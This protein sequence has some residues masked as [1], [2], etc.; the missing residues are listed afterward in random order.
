MGDGFTGDGA[1][2]IALIGMSGRYPGAR[3]LRE[4]WHNLCAGVESISFFSEPELRAAGVSP[5][6]L[7]SGHYVPARGVLDDIEWFDAGFFGYAPREAELM[8]PQHRIFLECAWEA[9]E[10]AGYDPGRDPGL[11][12]VYAG[13]GLNTY[14]LN[15]LSPQ[16]ELLEAVGFYQVLIGNDKDYLATRV[17][18]KLN[19]K[20][21]SMTVQTA[22]STSLVAVYQACQG[23]LTYQCDMALAGGVAIWVPHRVGYLHTQGGILSP[24]GHCRAFDAAAQGTVVGNGVGIVVLKRLDDAL[25]DGDHIYA[26]IQ[27]IACNNDG[28]DKIGFTAPGVAGQARVIREALALANVD[29]ATISYVEAH[30]TGTPLGDPIEMAALAQ[31]FRTPGE[32]RGTCAIGSV[33]SNIGHTDAAAGVAGLIKTALA[34]QHRQI[35]PSLHLTAVNPK[36]DLAHS[37]FTVQQ[38]LTP[39]TSNGTPRRAGVSSFGLGGTNVHAVLEEAPPRRPASPGRPWQ[40]LLLSARSQAGVHAAAQRLAEH[41]QQ[42]PDTDLADVAYT[43]AVGRRTFAQRMAVVCQAPGDAM[44]ALA[45]SSPRLYDGTARSVVFMFSGQGAQH[46]DMGCALYAAEPIFRQQVDRCAEQLVPL[47]GLD[48]REVLF[49]S[50]EQTATMAQLL[51]ETWITQPALFTIEYAL[52]QLWLA[53]GIR[54]AALIGHSIGEY[55]AACLAG[56]MDLADA[57]RLVASRGQLMQQ[58]APGAMLAVMQP[59]AEVT[60]LLPDQLS[61]AAINGPALCVVS[62]PLAGIEALEQVLVAR[63]IEC[64]RLQ[65]SHAFHSAMMDP[66]AAS[67][68]T[69]ASQID[70][71]PPQIPFVSNVTGDWITPAAAT[72]PAYWA[73]HLRAPVQFAQGIQTILHDPRRI[74]LEVGPGRT[75]CTLA[76]Q[77]RG[78]AADL[79]VQNSLP[80]PQEPAAEQACL[81]QAL[82]RLWQAGVEVDWAAFYAGQRRRRV[83]LPTYPF[84]RQYYWIEAPQVSSSADGPPPTLPAAPGA[85]F[86]SQGPATALTDGPTA[87]SATAGAAGQATPVEQIVH[88]AWQEVLGVKQVRPDDSFFDLG[89]HSLQAV[90]LAARLSTQLRRE[91]PV[92]LILTNPRVAGLAAALSAAGDHAPPRNGAARPLPA[93][94]M[95]EAR[96]WPTVAT[97]ERR[98]LLAL[99]AAGRLA[100]VDAAALDY[101]PNSLLQNTGLRREEIIQAWCDDLPVV[102]S[103]WEIPLGRMAYIVLPRFSADL[104]SDP[105]DAVRVVIEGLQVA[106]RLGA[107]TVSLTGLIPSATDYGRAVAAA[108]AGRRDLPQITT[109]HATTTASVVLAIR[110]MLHEAGRDLRQERLAFVGLGS[111]GL[112]SL[113][114]LLRVLPPPADLTL[115]DVYAKQAALYAL[116]AEI[117]AQPGWQGCVHVVEAGESLPEAVYEA[118]LIVGATNVPGILD[119]SRVRPG[120]LIVD[121]SAPHCFDPRLAWRRAQEQGDILFTE[122]GMLESPAAVQDTS[123]VPR[124]AEQIIQ[125]DQL[126]LYLRQ[127]PHHL[128]GCV[129]SS[130]L[131]TRFDHLSPTLG[132][133]G[134]DVA[135]QHYQVLDELG[136]R[137]APLHCEGVGLPAAAIDRFRQQCAAD[138]VSSISLRRIST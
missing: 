16:R 138:S 106:R 54:P 43:L 121:D 18:Y 129:L 13:A 113:R 66:A 84:N 108:I 60:A 105:D 96:A 31:V 91:V 35:P 53:W 59:A 83:S 77:N 12:G 47:L 5:A 109:G 133:V 9:L 14:L 19:L 131:S 40:L 61:I 82:G 90:Q 85:P 89:G 45:E 101:L 37:P 94:P 51:G 24:D 128:W 127:Q 56:V 25:A 48:L 62:G 70:L 76:M 57:L 49:P 8:D 111:I 107:R 69:V 52:A 32:P 98:S 6:A 95:I 64:R 87:D 136:F 93:E 22:C 3:N 92:K 15:N 103:I 74:L 27:G 114:L 110:R 123:Y 115:C 42:Q 118:S 38:T 29:P 73:R 88:A 122:G 112:T 2:G 81:L 67:L 50:D 71:H 119:I 68:R 86:P 7:A 30:G 17:S 36:I 23:L 80:H 104:Y 125:N 100:P 4:F 124:F 55:V 34:L 75:L 46:I 33:K 11:T 137:A 65:T 58:A 1:T 39:W 117:A 28:A 99:H 21:P 72:D 20:G 78:E 97:I 44:A 130:L 116:H 41:L 26:V 126:Q 134:A 132:I 79:V 10:D 120:T 63:A 102:Q 135:A